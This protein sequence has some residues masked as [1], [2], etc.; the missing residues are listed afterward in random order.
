MQHPEVLARRSSDGPSHYPEHILPAQRRQPLAHPQG[1]A[2]RMSLLVLWPLPVRHPR[3]RARLTTGPGPPSP[4][5]L[6]TRQSQLRTHLIKGSIST[7]PRERKPLLSRPHPKALPPH[8]M[9]KTPPAWRCRPIL[10]ARNP[11][12]LPPVRRRGTT[13]DRQTRACPHRPLVCSAT[14]ATRSEQRG[15]SGRR[16]PLTLTRPVPLPA[17]R[18]CAG[19]GDL[20]VRSSC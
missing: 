17:A 4:P 6:P 7:M 15:L 9:P 16:T 20:G 12:S 1:Q 11:S 13:P 5:F 8:P 18:R 10:E 19:R 2:D 14:Y 3:S